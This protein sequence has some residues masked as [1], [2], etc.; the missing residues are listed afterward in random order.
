MSKIHQN[1]ELLRVQDQNYDIVFNYDKHEN[2]GV[3]VHAE[4]D[5][6]NHKVNHEYARAALVKQIGSGGAWPSDLPKPSV[7]GYGYT[8]QSNQT[9]ITWDGDTSGLVSVNIEDMVYYKV[10]NNTPSGDDLIGGRVVYLNNIGE[11]LNKDITPERI[12]QVGSIISI[13]NVFI[14]LE[15]NYTISGI[16]FPEKGVYFEW[17]VS[18]DNIICY[19]KSLTY[20]TPDTVHKIDE[21]Y[22]PEA[23]GGMMVGHILYNED[24]DTYSCDKTFAELSTA[25]PNVILELELADSE[26]NIVLR[27][28]MY[29][30]NRD[31]I[32]FLYLN[33][34]GSDKEVNG[35][36]CYNVS[37]SYDDSVQVD[38][39]ERYF[40]I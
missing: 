5:G 13:S 17:R 25:V 12:M 16:T 37:I 19:T 8:E 4:K 30:I 9:T 27:P 34:F 23:G 20:G 15:D 11:L 22:L 32:S 3:A 36:E 1:D 38:Y 6:K 18:Y 24:D 28:F 2:G 10:S 7:G 29:G 14:S 40:G 35:I 31:F 21:K 26:V 39:Y 33:V